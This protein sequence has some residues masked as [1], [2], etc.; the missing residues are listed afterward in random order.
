MNYYACKAVAA[1]LLLLS[2]TALLYSAIEN[3]QDN[4]VRLL[5]GTAALAMAT[6]SG[7]LLFYGARL[8]ATAA[9]TRLNTRIHELAAEA[10]PESESLGL[11][12]D[13]MLE[14]ARFNLEIADAKAANREW[15]AAEH[16]ANMG[17]Q[18]I[19]NYWAALRSFYDDMLTQARFHLDVA[20]AKLEHHEW[21]YAVHTANMGMQNIKNYRDAAADSNTDPRKL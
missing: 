14:S 19:Q 21:R 15:S 10:K 20:N 12:Y 7:A 11:Y 1:I 17:L 6:L 3:S 8:Q 18:N 4:S 9:I 13:A 16:C 2:S 5:N